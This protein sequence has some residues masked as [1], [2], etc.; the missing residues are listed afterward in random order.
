MA[1]VY[2]PISLPLKFVRPAAELRSH[3]RTGRGKFRGARSAQSTL[4]L[5]FAFGVALLFL[6]FAVVF[7]LGIAGRRSILGSGKETGGGGREWG[8]RGSRGLLLLVQWMFWRGKE[9]NGRNVQ[10]RS[11]LC[12]LA[13]I[14][15]KSSAL[16]SSRAVSVT[17]FD[18]QTYHSPQGWTLTVELLGRSQ[19]HT[20]S[21]LLIEA[22]A[23]YIHTKRQARQ[24]PP[25]PSVLRSCYATLFR[26]GISIRIVGAFLHVLRDVVPWV[27]KP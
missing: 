25:P 3:A 21:C 11:G 26:S 10:A 15:E 22:T 23:R 6:L 7:L 4:R 19:S 27:A 17:P 1:L 8:V 18:D 24:D 12:E 14:R 2:P 5:C 13:N 9:E 20:E 16:W